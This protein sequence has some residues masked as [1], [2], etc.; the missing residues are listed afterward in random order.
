MPFSHTQS[1]DGDSDSRSFEDP[2]DVQR[3]EFYSISRVTPYR[4]RAESRPFSETPDMQQTT[5]Q[6]DTSHISADCAP[7]ELLKN[8]ILM[9]FQ[10]DRDVV[11]GRLSWPLTDDFETVKGQDLSRRE[12]GSCRTGID[13]ESCRYRTLLPASYVTYF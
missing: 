13:W 7:N 1:R 5:T 12:G 9:G 6:T 11:L 3:C 8:Y 4:P 2:D 10:L